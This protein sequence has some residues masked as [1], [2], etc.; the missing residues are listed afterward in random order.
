MSKLREVLL[1]LDT[2]ND[3]HWTG[4][5][6][7]RLE[8]VR[9]LIG[10]QSVTREQ[11]TQA[12]PG[13]SRYT[14]E[15]SKEPAVTMPA[16]VELMKEQT[17]LKLAE[18]RTKLEELFGHR[19]KL[20]ALIREQQQ[21]VDK[22]VVEVEKETAVNKSSATQEYLKRQRMNLQER[23]D[24]MALIRDSGINFKELLSNL[25]SPLDQKL[26]GRRRH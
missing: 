11:I 22:Y 6:L 21:L 13:F 19:A 24:K 8:T 5:G 12:V 14:Q 10:D 3:N 17:E 15:T 16:V 2:A 9:V 20:E 4:E 23:A 25:K 26:A 1:K 7:P 18:E